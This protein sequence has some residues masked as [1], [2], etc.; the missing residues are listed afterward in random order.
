MMR[1]AATE[2][3]EKMDAMYRY[4]RY[5]Y[6]ATRRFY[7][8]GRDRLIQKMTIG[9]GDRVAEIGCG[10]GRNL[11]KLSELYPRA[12]FYGL[13]AS[14]E[15]LRTASD[16]IA[17]RS[18]KNIELRTALAE[19]FSGLATFGLED[20]FDAVFFSYS[21]SMVPPWKAAIENALENLKPGGVMYIVDF[22]DQRELP[23]LFRSALKAWL[24]QFHVQFWGDLIPFLFELN[25]RGLG[26]LEI[27]SVSRRYA[28]IASF[29]KT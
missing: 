26:R 12:K 19:S 29:T 1:N 9:E 4:Q 13:D 27:E 25:G 3:Y 17:A 15:M 28:F 23:S 8:L 6:D 22:Y 5:F 21:I 14:A 11:I 16:N 7:L 24:R 20:P 18:L 2:P 10:T